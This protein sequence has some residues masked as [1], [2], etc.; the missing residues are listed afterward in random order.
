[1]ATYSDAGPFILHYLS[2]SVV[3]VASAR[4]APHIAKIKFPVRFSPLSAQS[5]SP[6][7]ALLTTCVVPVSRDPQMIFGY[8]LVGILCGPYF[9]QLIPAANFYDLHYISQCAIAYFAYSA[10]PVLSCTIAWLA[11]SLGLTLLIGTRSPWD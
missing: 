11:V 8:V 10:G 4:L 2:F 9:L 5:P 1:M 6:W 7:T 3:A